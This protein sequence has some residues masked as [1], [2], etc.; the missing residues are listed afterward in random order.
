MLLALAIAAAATC[1]LSGQS[2]AVA[3]PFSP[4]MVLPAG[5]ATTL[6]GTAMPGKSIAVHL[7]GHALGTSAGSDGKW[8][9]T[10]P[11]M[12]ATAAA[13][14][15]TITCGK[16]S[17]VLDDILAGEVWLA[18]GQSNMAYPMVNAIG[19]KAALAGADIPGLRLCAL[20]APATT[21]RAFSPD[22]RARL[23]PSKLFTGNWQRS[24]PTSAAG[25][26]AIAWWAAKLRHERTGIPIGIIGNAVGGS[27]TEAWVPPAWLA[28][29]PDTAP[30][31]AGTWLDHPKISAWARG[32]AKQNLGDA[33]DRSHPFMPGILFS[34]GVEWWRG[35]PLA[36]VLWYQGETNAEI[37]DPEWNGKL[38]RGVILGW[39]DAL[40]QPDLPF[41]VVQLPRIGG[42]DPL[43][44]FW[45]EYRALQ[46]SVAASLPHTRLIVTSDLGYDSPDVHPPDKLPV[47]RRMEQSMAT[48]P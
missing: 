1:H 32:R 6:T 10:L 22:E 24:T 27:G 13:M 2:L 41:H 30:L 31:L 16:D 46:N 47:A 14:T 34:A 38:L 36:G 44:R 37:H 7:A 15:L 12:P 4:H 25:F 19:G 28:K 21:D 29:D 11:V 3:R 8:S 26:S 20:A 17:L 23:S 33:V 5:K 42:T 35:Y 9:V 45:P 39:R 40:G 48:P 18:S 43:R